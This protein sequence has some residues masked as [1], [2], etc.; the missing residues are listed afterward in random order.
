MTATV[1]VV[2]RARPSAADSHGRIERNALAFPERQLMQGAPA[3]QYAG[4][5]ST[6]DI[7]FADDPIF[8]PK[9]RKA[10]LSPGFSIL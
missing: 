10:G 5:A 1:I 7:Q 4:D 9:R 2:A 3:D 8:I 6:P